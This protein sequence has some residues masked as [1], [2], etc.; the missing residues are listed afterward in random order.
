MGKIPKYIPDTPQGADFFKIHTQIAEMLNKTILSEDVSE[1]SFTFG[2]LGSWGSGKSLTVGKLKDKI[3]TNNNVI[4]FEFDVWKY[5]DT[6]LYRS[7]LIDFEKALKIKSEAGLVPES[8]KT[9]IKT[10][11]GKNLHDVLYKSTQ[12]VTPDI[13]KTEDQLNKLIE[14]LEKNKMGKLLSFFSLRI[15][16][17]LWIIG[18]YLISRSELLY[19]LLGIGLLFSW[20]YYYRSNIEIFLPFLKDPFLKPVLKFLLFTVFGFAALELFKESFKDLFKELLPKTNNNII[21]TTP[22]T[23]AQDQFENIFKGV[24]DQ[25]SDNGN[26]KIVIVFDNIDRCEA[27]VTIQILTGLKTFLDQKNCFY[28]IPCDD[29]RIKNHLTKTKRA[30]D[31]YLDK[32]FQAYIR[33]PLIEGDDKITFIKKCI[34]KADFELDKQ[35]ES[36]ISQILILAYKGQTPRQIKRFFNDFISYYR[37]AE[38]VDPNKEILLKDIGYFTFMIAIKQKWPEVENIIL[39]NP[40]FFKELDSSSVPPECFRFVDNCISWIDHSIDP[41]NFIYLKDTK[42]SSTQV[43]RIFIDGFNEFN[44]TSAL[45]QQFGNYFQSL[46]STNYFILYESG[47]ERLKEIIE[48]KKGEIDE[49][50]LLELFKVYFKNILIHSRS[51][52]QNKKR[53]YIL[54]HSKFISDHIQLINRIDIN[55]KPDVEREICGVLRNNGPSEDA[56]NLYTSFKDQFSIAN[57]KLIFNQI[58]YDEFIKLHPFTIITDK[59]KLLKIFEIGNIE[60]IANQISFN[61][62]ESSFINLVHYLISKSE[63]IPTR[64]IVSS[65]IILMFTQIQNHPNDHPYDPFILNGLFVLDSHCW[66]Q[67]EKSTFNTLLNARLNLLVRN[68]SINPVVNYSIEAIKNE[69]P[70]VENMFAPTGQQNLNA[71]N[72]FTPFI[73]RITETALIVGVENDIIKNHII[74][75]ACSYNLESKVIAKL[76]FHYLQSKLDLLVFDH[77]N[78]LSELLKQHELRGAEITDPS[79]LDG[80]EKSVIEKYILLHPNLIYEQYQA[81]LPL[82][83]SDTNK[84]Y[85]IEKSVEHFRSKHQ[86]NIMPISFL[87]NSLNN[88]SHN[89]ISNIYVNSKIQ[90]V[91]IDNNDLFIGLIGKLKNQERQDYIDRIFLRIANDIK[92]SGV[93]KIILQNMHSSLETK[94]FQSNQKIVVQIVNELFEPSREEIDNKTGVLILKTLQGQNKKQLFN[95]EEKLRFLEESEGKSNELKDEIKAIFN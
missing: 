29:L 4:F 10:T 63:I 43:Q 35:N 91:E 1:N 70:C 87:I 72:V 18:K 79:L 61:R 84:N 16:N 64:K 75:I 59:D 93:S 25:I 73:D 28:L 21:I 3:I 36:K 82:I 69:I 15:I 9:G 67:N 13:K 51:A 6:S 34:E 19:F 57:L 37:L 44:I 74:K 40:N 92:T 39:Q 48:L 89:T 62:D 52:I 23:F 49:Y 68:G 81:L 56:K 33:I 20:A 58:S 50:L 76:N 2:L 30:E 7:I 71:L 95:L 5:F 8:Y 32:I 90:L 47:I 78:W 54:S 31:D 80:F 24:I 60:T 22:P 38:T 66:E 27:N 41:A 17:T 46:N 86:E 85:Y 55:Q 26:K 83:K 42:N 94:D 12:V 11:E 65:K 14:T 53:T 77:L 88:N 45:I